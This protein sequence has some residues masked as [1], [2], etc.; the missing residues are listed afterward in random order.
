MAEL[1]P[2]G[3]ALPREHLVPDVL[4]LGLNIVFCGTA[5]G[6]KSAREKAYYA[7]PGNY[8]WRTLHHIGLTPRRLA[9]TEYKLVLE[10]GLGLTDL[11]KTNYG[12]D[13][14][15]PRDAFD[16]VALQEK[17][18]RYQPRYLAFTSKT[19]AALFLNRPAAKLAYGLQPERIGATQLFVL[20]SPSG[21]AR[22]FW[23]ETHWQT[24]SDL[25]KS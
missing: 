10:Y 2:R 6:V 20:P 16:M 11:S 22:I 1:N 9:P 7:N 15:I 23:N 18:F 12:Q 3:G 5:L 21:Q 24:L 14:D 4:A 19:G 8:F 13:A 17:I 25:A